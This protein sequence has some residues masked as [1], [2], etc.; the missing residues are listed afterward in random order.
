MG[1][2]PS[3]CVRLAPMR[4]RR[5][6]IP[7]IHKPPVHVSVYLGPVSHAVYRGS[8]MA[9]ERNSALTLTSIEAITIT[10]T[11]KRPGSF[12]TIATS[13]LI[14]TLTLTKAVPTGVRGTHSQ[15]HAN[16]LSPSVI[17]GILGSIFGFILLLLLLFCYCRVPREDT[18]S[19]SEAS[20]EPARYNRSPVPGVNTISHEAA[21][22]TRQGPIRRTADGSYGQTRPRPA[23]RKRRP[24][25]NEAHEEPR[26][27]DVSLATVGWFAGYYPRQASL[28]KGGGT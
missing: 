3:S 24:P 19:D 22:A 14:T 11:L 5:L 2:M 10:Q 18:Y 21:A 20:P 7:Q 25:M 8:W 4:L 17:G 16:G 13:T 26:N 27:I 23:R 6:D 9:T 15:S 28:L 1:A 12:P